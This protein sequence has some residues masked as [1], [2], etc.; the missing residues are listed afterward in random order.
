MI[1]NN[2]YNTLSRVPSSM[3]D[4]ECRFTTLSLFS[5]AQDLAASHYGSGGL[6]IPHLQK[7]GITWVIAKQHFEITEYPLWEDSLVLQTWALP[8]KGPFF[9][10]DFKYSYAP[11]GKYTTLDDAFAS[12]TSVIP[13]EVAE[14]DVFARGISSWMIVDT[15]TGKPIKPDS[16]VMGSLSFCSDEALPHVFP[17]IA[18][19]DT[20]DWEQAFSP[21]LLDIDVNNHVNNLS[22]TRWILSF[23]NPETVQGKLVTVLDN[24]FIS[25]AQFGQNLICR[26]KQLDE[27]TFVH[28]IIREDSSEVFKAKTQWTSKEKVSRPLSLRK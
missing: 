22:Y 8:I 9:F 28:W 25:S 3:I 18:N 11:K 15:S 27:N 14:E 21:T 24:Y 17:K 19:T 13:N 1:I 23:M 2:K 12:P 6:S 16:A 7:K 26:V 5:L 20:W 10:R 4:G